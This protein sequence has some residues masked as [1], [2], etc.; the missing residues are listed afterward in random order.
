MADLTH[1]TFS[2]EVQ[3]AGAGLDPVRANLLFAREI[4]YPDLRPEESWLQLDDLAVAAQR[5][6]RAAD[7]ATRAQALAHFLSERA[8]FRGDRETYS[9]PRNSYINDVLER[10]LGLP[11]SLAVLYVH[12]ARRCGLAAEG[13]GLPGH[14]IV[15][16]ATGAG[17]LLLDPFNGG[18][19]LS[20]A[21]CQRLVAQTAGHSGPL[22]PRWLAPTPGREIVARMLNNLRGSYTALEAWPHA[23]RVVE[24]LRELQP[25][26]PGHLRDLGLLHYK[27]GAHLQAA[28]ILGHYLTLAPDAA[29]ADEIRRSRQLLRDEGARWN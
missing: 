7:P 18:A 2:A 5:T 12:L 19:V 10:R 17:R 24:R 29:D 23:I 26:Q 13:V 4:A 14:F 8:G 6:L 25:D 15:G 21:D 1:T 16:V 11:I 9:D 3:A 20:E 27:T 28:E 22:D